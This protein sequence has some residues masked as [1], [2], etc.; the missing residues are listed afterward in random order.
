MTPL[1]IIKIGGN[2]IDNSENLY[3]FL[4]DFTALDGYKILVTDPSPEGQSINDIDVGEKLALVMGNEVLGISDY[5]VQ[6]ADAKVRIPM[7][8][9]TESF[10][11]SVS[12]AICLNTL[13]LKLRQS[14]V[15]WHLSDQELTDMRLKWFRK[16]V[17]RSDIIEKEFLRS[18]K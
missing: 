10:N 11:I 2:V 13:L 16:M 6:H 1:H 8:G 3:H 5:A 14:E 4:K 12:A 17:R 7:Y 18:F 15:A 9:F